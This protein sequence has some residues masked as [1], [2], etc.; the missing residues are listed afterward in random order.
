MPRLS[1]PEPGPCGRKPRLPLYAVG[2]PPWGGVAAHR[3]SSLTVGR[4]SPGGG[5]CAPMGG[6]AARPIAGVS[7][8]A[9]GGCAGAC[10]RE[11]EEPPCSKWVSA[12][13]RSCDGGSGG[14]VGG[15]RGSDAVDDSAE[16]GGPAAAAVA[17]VSDGGGGAAL[18]APPPD[19]TTL[20]E[21]LSLQALTARAGAAAAA[22]WWP[23]APPEKLSRPASA[24]E[25]RA[26]APGGGA[27][28]VPEPPL[29]A[30]SRTSLDRKKGECWKTAGGR[31]GAR[32]SA[33]LRGGGAPLATPR[34]PAQGA[35]APRQNKRRA[36]AS[37]ATGAMDGQASMPCPAQEHKAFRRPLTVADVADDAARVRHEEGHDR[38]HDLSAKP[39]HS[40]EAVARLAASRECRQ[41]QRQS[42]AKDSDTGRAGRRPRRVTGR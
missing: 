26:C 19:A 5:A 17:A 9:R 18:P 30:P 32:A 14:G 27:A 16:R 28:A 34:N 12:S 25:V 24:L 8:R 7:W 33:G 38:L 4:C 36:A 3:P 22:A 13:R 41:R 1:G 42:A 6:R 15:A 10:A 11:R 31:A 37:A 39:Q 40:G 20:T 29:A 21:K 35:T 2:E 23:C